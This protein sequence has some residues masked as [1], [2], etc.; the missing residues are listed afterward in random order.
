VRVEQLY[1]F[2]ERRLREILLRYQHV[3]E[4]AWVQEEPKNMGAW[5]HM[6]AYC[7][8]ALEIT[9]GYIGRDANASPAAGSVRMH[10]QEQERIMVMALGLPTKVEVEQGDEARR[11]ERTKARG[12]RAVAAKRA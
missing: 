12:G 9:L 10:E 4:L 2:P 8:E 3:E 6:D 7:R 1:P 5:R 11:D